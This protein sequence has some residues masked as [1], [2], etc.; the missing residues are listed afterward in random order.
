MTVRSASKVGGGRSR[1]ATTRWTLI[2]RAAHESGQESDAALA[3]LCELYWYPVYAFVRRKGYESDA[4]RDLTQ[5]FF[6]RLL[7]REFLATADRERGRFRAFLLTAVQHFLA[8]EYDR[9]RAQKRGGGRQ[10]VPL[11]F[12]TGEERYCGEPQLTPEALYERRWA[13]TLLNDAMRDLRSDAERGGWR[14]QLAALE[15]V[16]AGNEQPLR[17]IA[18]C[19]GMS[20]G[21]LRVALHRL[22]RRFADCIRRRIADTVASSGDIDGEIAYLMK[23]V[24]RGD[25]A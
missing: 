8:N 22:R 5:A 12:D 13:L 6:T 14:Q 20:E 17:E 9:E 7:E 19:L 11:D 18:G 24:G 3:S 15:P 10:F 1:L 16:L 2:L 21:A 4:A 25:R 23:A